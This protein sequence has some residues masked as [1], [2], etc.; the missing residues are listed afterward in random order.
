MSSRDQR[1]PSSSNLACE[2]LSIP[3]DSLVE[4]VAP[5]YGLDDA[6]LRWHE[7]LINFFSNLGFQRSLLE[8]CW[9]IKRDVKGNAQAHVLIEVDDINI[10]ATSDYGAYLRKAL[11]ARFVFGKWEEA[12]ADTLQADMSRLRKIESCST[13]RSISWRR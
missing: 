7:T 10:G 4:L 1:V 6:P 13:K 2:G 11:E 3:E 5:V 8:P 9:W 12:E